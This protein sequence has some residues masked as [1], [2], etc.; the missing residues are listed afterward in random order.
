MGSSWMLGLFLT[1]QIQDLSSH[2]RIFSGGGGPE[3]LVRRKKKKKEQN[4]G[5]P[6]FAQ[7]CNHF[8]GKFLK[9]Q[10]LESLTALGVLLVPGPAPETQTHLQML[11]LPKRGPSEPTH[12]RHTGKQMPSCLLCRARGWRQSSW[13][14]GITSTPNMVCL[15]RV[16]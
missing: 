7:K 3:R 16:A 9:P 6:K 5:V 1:S 10:T 4:K 11:R 13:G 2:L 12:A 14:D 8:G 15:S